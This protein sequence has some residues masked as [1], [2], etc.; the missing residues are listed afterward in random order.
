MF[1]VI[2]NQG[3]VTRSGMCAYQDIHVFDRRACPEKCILDMCKVRCCNI[4]K[5]QDIHSGKNSHQSI[6]VPEWVR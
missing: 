4:I 6:A 3:Q 5:E 2:C 1:F